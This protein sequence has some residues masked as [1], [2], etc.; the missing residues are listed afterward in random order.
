MPEGGHPQKANP[1]LASEGDLCKR[2]SCNLPLISLLL[3]DCNF[4]TWFRKGNQSVLYVVAFPLRQAGRRRGGQREKQRVFLLPL[5]HGTEGQ[6]GGSGERKVTAT[7]A[8]PTLFRSRS[9]SSR[10]REN[11]LF[12]CSTLAAESCSAVVSR[13]LLSL[14]VCSSIS[15]FF[16]L[17]A[18]PGGGQA[19]T[20]RVG[21]V[22]PAALGRGD[23]ATPS[24]HAS[25]PHPLPPVAWRRE[26]CAERAWHLPLV[27]TCC[28]VG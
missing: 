15:H 27:G 3:C 21:A 12:H 19:V 11:C 25:G 4:K 16:T 8:L 9:F 2:Q 18:L 17:A 7:L 22:H 28:L 6:V 20:G 10:Q 14:R 23:P 1:Q 13:A 26:P 5:G 24:A